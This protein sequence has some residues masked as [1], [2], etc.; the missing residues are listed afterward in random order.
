MAEVYAAW[1]LVWFPDCAAW[2]S[3]SRKLVLY[4]LM[5]CCRDWFDR[6]APFCRT[7]SASRA[8][9]AARS[10]LFC[11]A[12][13]HITP[14]RWAVS[15]MYVLNPGWI[16]LSVC[17]DSGVAVAAG[18]AAVGVAEG[19]CA[20]GDPAEVVIAPAISERPTASET[21]PPPMMLRLD[22]GMC[23]CPFYLAYAYTSQMLLVGT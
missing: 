21:A 4:A 7:P 1:K 16:W 12:A 20:T 9:K 15:I 10:Q 5:P 17:S 22:T 6:T 19:C 18:A 14:K 13:N 3:G 2:I 23:W 8:S 11:W